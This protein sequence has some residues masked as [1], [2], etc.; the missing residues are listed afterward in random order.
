MAKE[1]DRPQVIDVELTTGETI[2]VGVLNW[3]GYKK[4]KPLIIERLA[5]RAGDVFSDPTAMEKGAAAM[6]PLMAALDEILG[7]LTPD[8]VKACVADASTLK[9]VTRP[10]DWLRLREGA[11]VVNDLAEILELEGNALMASVTTV[12][13][14]VV[15]LSDQTDGGSE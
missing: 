4:L 10:V 3:N 13:K 1:K 7:D 5:M 8:F 2:K 6:A 15:E 12:M 14:R 9:G 11:A